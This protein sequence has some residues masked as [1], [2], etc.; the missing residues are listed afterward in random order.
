MLQ[1]LPNSMLQTSM[2]EGSWPMLPSNNV[3]IYTSYFYLPQCNCGKVMFLYVSVILSTVG[4]LAEPTWQADT[5][6]RQTLP[7]KQTP[8]LAGSTPWAGNPQNRH[9]PVT[10]TA[11]D[12]THPT[13]MHSCFLH[14]L[15]QDSIKPDLN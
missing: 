4:V 10:A 14:M 2:G 11:A 8:L 9:P 12:G 1:S 6:S 13:G 15:S 5:P 3:R 7:G